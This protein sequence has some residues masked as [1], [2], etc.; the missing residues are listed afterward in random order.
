MALILHFPNGC[1]IEHLFMCLFAIFTCSSVKCLLISFADF[2]N[3]GLGYSLTFILW[4]FEKMYILL[5]NGVLCKCPLD[6][7]VFLVYWVFLY[8][9]VLSV[10]EREMLKAPRAGLSVSTFSSISVWFIYWEVLILGTFKVR[11]IMSCWW[12]DPFIM[13]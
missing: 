1:D 12:I 3:Y 9:V 6:P 11:V 5:F 7:I 10:V 8:L 2:C 4:L 13:T